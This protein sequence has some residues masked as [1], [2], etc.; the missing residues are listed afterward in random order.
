MK[1]EAVK[2]GKG[3][4]EVEADIASAAEHFINLSEQKSK[5]VSGTTYKDLGETV[6]TILASGFFVAA[7]NKKNPP[8][9]PEE[10]VKEDEDEAAESD[11]EE[12]DET[13]EEEEIDVEEKVAPV[14]PQPGHQTNGHVKDEEMTNA[15][16]GQNSL[17]T[18]PSQEVPANHPSNHINHIAQEQ[19]MPSVPVQH[20]QQQ[21]QQ[22][23]PQ[24]QPQRPVEPK[25]PT[26]EPSFNFLQ[27]SQIDIES[28]MMD[29][30]VVMVQGARKPDQSF[31]PAP[32]YQSLPHDAVSQQLLQQHAAVL[33]HHQ[34]QL[35]HQQNQ[36]QQQIQQ[37]Q[38]LRQQQPQ[39]QQYQGQQ[40]TITTLPADTH[41]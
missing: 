14:V 13:E 1:C 7:A 40:Q 32:M 4:A 35:H 8:P 2:P 34:Q 28:P 36:G 31:P 3:G 20:Q 9:P 25:Q 5:P 26:P 33:A 12:V 16:L 38:Q 27:E 19:P 17:P 15:M 39:Q 41:S 22:Q 37:Q 11:D 6:N 24:Q 21:Q 10:E 29:P 18:F 23:P 30:A